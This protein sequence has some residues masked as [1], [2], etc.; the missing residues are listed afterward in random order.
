MKNKK[1]KKQE[2]DKS[3]QIIILV[4]S[5]F[6][7]S[8]FFYTGTNIKYQINDIIVR[9]P[10]IKSVVNSKT[11]D[12]VHDIKVGVAIDVSKKNQSKLNQDSLYS[13]VNE[14]ISNLDYDLLIG[15]NGFNYLVEK[16]RTGLDIEDVNGIYISEFQVDN[17]T[18]M[19]DKSQK[20]SRD[21]NLK[22]ITK[23]K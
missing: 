22:A 18:P 7:I 9:V 8:A 1:Q 4:L 23:F 2:K 17:L 11:S 12:G 16:I 10:V 19:E 6:A 5:L 14:I 3:T 20:N 15:E 21:E 13:E